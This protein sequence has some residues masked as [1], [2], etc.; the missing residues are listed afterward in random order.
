MDYLPFLFPPS[1]LFGWGF[2]F[3]F[4]PSHF[5]LIPTATCGYALTRTVIWILPLALPNIP[6]FPLGSLPVV[7]FLAPPSSGNCGGRGLTSYILEITC[8]TLFMHPLFSTYARI[9]H[10]VA[11]RIG[12][13]LTRWFLKPAEDTPL[14]FE[15]KPPYRTSGSSP[16]GT[17]PLGLPSCMKTLQ[18]LPSEFGTLRLTRAPLLLEK[19]VPGFFFLS[20]HF[21]THLLFPLSP[22]S[23]V[24]LSLFPSRSVQ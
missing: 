24:F 10:F 9:G 13:F 2:F 18:L 16:L 22:C 11:F 15:L 21:L 6:V 12:L 17:L 7:F 4:F 3:F 20:C 1:P 8:V 19:S 5:P 14:C 23:P